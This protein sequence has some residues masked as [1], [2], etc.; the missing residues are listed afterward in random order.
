MRIIEDEAGLAATV[1]SGLKDTSAPAGEDVAAV[2]YAAEVLRLLPSQIRLDDAG[3]CLNVP[4][5]TFSPGTTGDIVGSLDWEM[6]RDYWVTHSDEH[7][8]VHDLGSALIAKFVRRFILADPEEF[9]QKLDQPAI[10]LANH[11]LYVESFLFLSTITALTGLPVEAIAKKEHQGT[12]IGETYQ[13]AEAEMVNNNPM[14]M[15]FLDREDPTDLLQILDDYSKTVADRPRS[16]LVHVEGTRAKQ[17]GQRTEKISSVL[18]DLCTRSRIPIVPVRFAGGL[19]LEDN[20]KLDFPVGFGGQDHYIGTRIE[21]DEL[22]AL[23]YNERTARILD[24]INSLGP[25]DQM[26]IPLP[27]DPVFVELVNTAG[28]LNSDSTE[29]QQVLWSALQAMP[30][31][32]AKMQNLLKVIASGKTGSDTLS[33]A[34]KIMA[35]M[36]GYNNHR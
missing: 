36:L 5:N 1:V 4:L 2:E 12:W 19:P 9:Q 10:Y 32:G 17:A 34:E 18:V 23:P 29:V 21:A 16:L 8:L 3:Q 24:G 14:Q 26:D 27:E 20:G 30:E 31:T 28:T 11:Q 7:Y 35:K 33:N 15:L 25:I 6:I 13:L 22:D